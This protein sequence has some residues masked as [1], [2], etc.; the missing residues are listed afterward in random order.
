MKCQD[1]VVIQSTSFVCVCVL[2]DASKTKQEEE[3]F[4]GY[5]ADDDHWRVRDVRECKD[6]RRRKSGR[7]VSRN[8]A[9]RERKVL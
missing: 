4:N 1:K 5:G 8:C 7:T 6:R 9:Q 3:E 2:T